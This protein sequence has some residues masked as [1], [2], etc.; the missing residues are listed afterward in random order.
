MI[1]LKPKHIRNVVYARFQ[2]DT[3]KKNTQIYATVYE[4]RELTFAKIARRS[5]WTPRSAPPVGSSGRDVTRRR[6]SRI[7]GKTTVAFLVSLLSCD[8]YQRRPRRRKMMI[9][10]C[11]R[12]SA[13]TLLLP[14]FRAKR[15]REQCRPV[16]CA[17]AVSGFCSETL[18]YAETRVCT[19]LT[20]VFEGLGKSVANDM[21]PHETCALF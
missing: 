4:R 7:G 1:K 15:L 21:Y 16:P 6:T 20:A 2:I 9:T 19:F 17:Y 13:L 18:D 8:R 14:S 11:R 12:S 10:Y 3:R 5:L